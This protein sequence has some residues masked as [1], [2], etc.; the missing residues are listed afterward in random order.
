MGSIYKT[1]QQNISSQRDLGK[2]DFASL[3][4]TFP[5]T[6]TY[7]ANDGI[8]NFAAL[9]AQ[10]GKV[11]PKDL[12]TVN[13]YY[14]VNVLGSD[15]K[16]ILITGNDQFPNFN[17]NFIGG[18]TDASQPLEKG[19]IVSDGSIIKSDAEPKLATD[20]A[21]AFVPNVRVGEI[22][23]K[24]DASAA[25]YQIKKNDLDGKSGDMATERGVKS[26]SEQQGKQI[27]GDYILGKYNS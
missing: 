4:A 10:P 16:T 6:P 13:S 27:L 5:N 18:Q 12:S 22:P 24:G 21:G 11:T 2:S 19:S 25:A 23:Q 26:L 14:F 8:A 17:P 9:K 20:P 3:K 7:K 1:T 15:D